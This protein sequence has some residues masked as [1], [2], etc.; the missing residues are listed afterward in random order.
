MTNYNTSTVEWSLSTWL[1]VYFNSGS[2]FQKLYKV[3][4]L[5]IIF[6]VALYELSFCLHH[7]QQAP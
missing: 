2:G 7:E 5:L 3:G 1:Q 4:I 6:A